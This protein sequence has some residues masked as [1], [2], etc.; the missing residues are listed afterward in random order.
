MPADF[1][2]N[3]CEQQ[4]RPLRHRRAER[5]SPVRPRA[6]SRALARLRSFAGGNPLWEAPHVHGELLKLGFEIAQSSIAKYMV[7][8]RGPPSQGWQTF[9]H[10]HAPDKRCGDERQ[11][12]QDSISASGGQPDKTFAATNSESGLALAM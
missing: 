3:E 11:T 10:N 1:M 5:G 4:D 12:Y 6:A 7:K 9:L 2:D 8:R